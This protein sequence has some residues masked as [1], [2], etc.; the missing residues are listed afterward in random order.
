M[1]RKKIGI[2]IA[3]LI[4]SFSAGMIAY[5]YVLNDFELMMAYIIAFTG[6]IIVLL[7]EMENK[8]V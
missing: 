6:W 8:N 7:D 2:A 5:N 4:A 3:T 1:T